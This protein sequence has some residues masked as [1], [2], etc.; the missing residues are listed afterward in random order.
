M[1]E[2]LGP[3]VEGEAATLA[4]L[5]L[6]ALLE[7][8]AA[9]TDRLHS[10]MAGVLLRAIPVKSAGRGRVYTGFLYAQL[11]DLRTHD[12]IDGRIPEGLVA[13]LEWN[14][15]AVFVGLLRF[16]S[17]RGTVLKPEFRID[18]VEHIGTMRLEGKSELLERWSGAAALPKRD[19]RAS[20][21]VDRP[22]L[23]VITG[24][25]SVAVDDI[26]AQLREA[27]G[28]IHLEVVRVSMLQP[29]EVTQALCQPARRCA[30]EGGQQNR[31][32]QRSAMAF[33]SPVWQ[34]TCRL[35]AQQDFDLRFSAQTK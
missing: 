28:E 19:M 17:G 31:V 7:S 1:F 12:T 14:R 35:Q 15:E 27:E 9:Q 6:T 32:M 24:V 22:R 20:L 26:R 13:E 4:P 23:V 25:G 29:A 21:Q 18:A 10:D 8:M 34:I 11:R 2:R 16:T 3:C 5:S 30:D 33:L